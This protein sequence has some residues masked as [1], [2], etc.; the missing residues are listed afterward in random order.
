M[1]FPNLTL[2]RGLGWNYKKSPKYST[3]MQV[4]QSMRHPAV[5]TLQ[6]GVIYEFELVFNYLKVA[7]VTTANDVA[8]LQAFYEALRGGYGW[9]TFDP[10]QYNLDTLSV[11]QDITQIVNGFSGVGDGVTTVF[12]LWRSTSALGGGSVTFCEMIQNVT[13]LFGVY[14]NGV[15]QSFGSF[16]QTNFPAS[17]T[18]SVAP[19]ANQVVSWNGTYNYLCRFDEDQLDFNEFMY[20]LW[21]LKSLRLES[22]NL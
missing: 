3:I 14:V 15:L 22:I 7:G 18:F 13:G 17:I 4:P 19:P 1:S 20:Q 10:S 2:P 5:A 8:Y 11:S 9:F 12:P 21:E 6:Q 16:T